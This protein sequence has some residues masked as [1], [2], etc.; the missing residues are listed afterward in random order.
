[1]SDP[2]EDQTA[3]DNGMTKEQEKFVGNFFVPDPSYTPDP[4]QAQSQTANPVDQ[5]VFGEY[6][7]SKVQAMRPLSDKMIV[8]GADTH[9]WT[10]VNPQQL[11]GIAGSEAANWFESLYGGD[12]SPWLE[13][14]LI[15]DKDKRDQAY[16]LL[17]TK[18]QAKGEIGQALNEKA[19]NLG[20]TGISARYAATTAFLASR[21]DREENG[22]VL[23]NYD[24]DQVLTPHEQLLLTEAVRA[25]VNP[26]GIGERALQ[27]LTPFSTGKVS[28]SIVRV[29]PG[30]TDFALDE[31]WAKAHPVKALAAS[32]LLQ[33]YNPGANVRIGENGV[34]SNV[35]NAAGRPIDWV[36]GPIALAYRYA[37]RGFG[38]MGEYGAVGDR[39]QYLKQ[40]NQIK[41]DIARGLYDPTEIPAAMQDY[42]RFLDWGTPGNINNQGESFSDTM[43][44]TFM[45][46]VGGWGL[47]QTSADAIGLLPGDPA[48]GAW[49]TAVGL[50]HNF[51]S[52]DPLGWAGAAK[53]AK[54]LAG[55]VRGVETEVRKAATLKGLQAAAKPVDYLRGR[56]WAIIGS[57]LDN[58]TYAENEARHQELLRIAQ[59]F[60][61]K[62]GYDVTQVSTA[63]GPRVM[64]LGM[65][66]DEALVTA[67]H[68]EQASFHTADGLVHTNRT[69]TP[70]D[71]GLSGKTSA[72]AADA[73]N[74]TMP[75]K[76]ES[77]NFHIP[78]D[79]KPVKFAPPRVSSN[80]MTQH[81]FSKMYRTPD[82]LLYGDQ[83]VDA[84]RQI[85]DTIKTARSIGRAEA[86]ARGITDAEGLLAAGEERTL[87]VMAQWAPNFDE[88]ITKALA[89]ARN[90]EDVHMVLI[91]A[92]LG[93]I[94]DPMQF[95]RIV[96]RLTNTG[97]ELATLDKTIETR[98]ELADQIHQ[99]MLDMGWN[100]KA[101][102]AS[103]SA[104]NNEMKGITPPPL[105]E[106][107]VRLFRGEGQ[108]STQSGDWFADNPTS[109]GRYG[110][111]ISYVDVPKEVAKIAQ[112]EA[113]AQGGVGY[114]LPPDVTA[115]AQALGRGADTRML[116]LSTVNKHADPELWNPTTSMGVS[117]LPPVPEGHVRLYRGHT[118]L[119]GKGLPEWVAKETE[120]AR[121]NWFTDKLEHA[122]W[123]AERAPEG[124]ISYVDVPRAEAE[125]ARV[126]NLGGEALSFSRDP[127][128]EFLLSKE[129]ASGMQP[130][131]VPKVGKLDKQEYDA[132]KADIEANGIR[133]PLEMD[134][135]PE[136]GKANM[137]E[138]F[139]RWMAARD[140][141]LERVPVRLTEAPGTE[142][143]VLGGTKL[144]DMVEN[145]QALDKQVIAEDARRYELMAER[146]HLRSLVGTD[147]VTIPMRELPGRDLLKQMRRFAPPAERTTAEKFMAA[148]ARYPGGVTTK[149]LMRVMFGGEVQGRQA[150][151]VAKKG[152]EFL[153][154]R[155]K[156][157][158]VRLGH[159]KQQ[160]SGGRH[161]FMPLKEGRVVP[162]G[163]MADYVQQSLSAIRDHAT[164]FGLADKD[165]QNLLAAYLNVSNREE[166][167]NFIKRLWEDVAD[168]SPFLDA[169][170]RRTL[171]QT[172][173]ELM[174]ERGSGY[175]HGDDE[176]F[177]IPRHTLDREIVDKQTGRNLRS[178]MP[179]FSADFMGNSMRLPPNEVM[180]EYL[181]ATRRWTRGLR[182]R[183]KLGEV[184]SEAIQGARDVLNGFTY[185]WKSLILMGRMPFA[186]LARLTGEQGFRMAAL[187]LASYANH[188]LEWLKS[189]LVKGDYARFADSHAEFLGTLMDNYNDVH[190]FGRGMKVYRR[191]RAVL[192]PNDGRAYFNALSSVFRRRHISPE[193]VKIMFRKDPVEVEN[194]LRSEASGPTGQAI[195]ENLEA[196]SQGVIEGIKN[197]KAELELLT[198]GRND[199][200]GALH[201]GHALNESGKPIEVGSRAFGEFLEREYEA[202]RYKPPQ[203]INARAS[204]YAFGEGQSLAARFRDFAF[205]QFYSRPD[206]YMSRAPMFR[207]LA[208][209]EFDRL[210]S[211]GWTAKRA[212]AAA[213]SYA[214]ETTSQWMYNL[215]SR[216]SAQHFLRNIIPFF[217]AYQELATVWL[218]QLPGRYV[219]GVGH[220][221]FARRAA[222]L[223]AAFRDIGFIKKDSNGQDYFTVPYLDKVY[224]HLTG[225]KGGILKFPVSSAVGMLP[226]TPDSLVPALGPAPSVAL[227][228]LAK[229]NA[230]VEDI[231]NL[232]LRYGNE[233]QIGPTSWDHLLHAAGVTPPWEYL[234]SDTQKL[235]M[236]LAVEDAMRSVSMDMPPAPDRLKFKSQK[237]YED[238]AKT[239]SEDLLARAHKRA[240]VHYLIR[241]LAGMFLP[242][243]VQV[244]NKYAEEMTGIWRAVEAYR[245]GKP[246][247]P[248]AA[249]PL[250]EAFKAKYPD[251]VWYTNSKTI[252]QGERRDYGDFDNF[253]K[254][255]TEGKVK[256]MSQQEF[257]DWNLGMTAY[258]QYLKDNKR[259]TN[260]MS[261]PEILRSGFQINEEKAYAKDDWS[262]YLAT[263][264]QFASL[265]DQFQKSFDDSGQ[266]SNTL[267]TEKL[268]A[269]K[270]Q[271]VALDKLFTTA[272]IRDAD[273]LKVIGKIS[274]N[275]DYV[276]SKTDDPRWQAVNWWWENVGIPTYSKIGDLYDKAFNLPAPERGPIFEKIRQI[277]N[278]MKP[279]SHKGEKY[280]TPEEVSWGRKND[281]EQALRKMEWVTMPPE[282]LTR[283]ERKKAGLGG[284][285][286][287]DKFYTFINDGQA[288]LRQ[289]AADNYVSTSS[290]DYKFN[291]DSLNT[292]IQQY[293]KEH[294]L[295]KYLLYTKEPVFQ[296]MLLAKQYDDNQTFV[297][298]AAQAR[299]VW[300]RIAADGHSPAGTTRE[301]REGQVWLFQQIDRAREIDQGFDNLMKRLELATAPSG[302]DKA[303]GYEMYFK[304]FF[305][306]FGPTPQLPSSYSGR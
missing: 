284:G 16:A 286:E 1:M 22:K 240:G 241:G 207:Q 82:E 134:F 130:L 70:F 288:K 165:V 7:G 285:P 77:V 159:V 212:K 167:F 25:S 36:S 27:V 125:A 218:K 115:R 40:A 45:P 245:E 151:R 177:M 28:N 18:D 12:I 263:H 214:A 271:L 133:E 149:D 275:I 292:A 160:L 179:A 30:S 98:A 123:Y 34:V 206:V 233:I 294:G 8:S 176:G 215:A 238:A 203:F 219:A 162:Q 85:Y 5:W 296:R 268:I 50:I 20:L 89:A 187:D 129:R 67:R 19:S 56:N 278:S 29:E 79:A 197:M 78:A 274:E 136:T 104:L 216:T 58:L 234:T 31:E 191:G 140:L 3:T 75:N 164:L 81:L 11:F 229:H 83:A 266:I 228:Q 76:F 92:M 131:E 276:A 298:I 193:T 126:S 189:M 302:R 208:V 41:Q 37:A 283:F 71:W 61:T 95:D 49:T 146:L 17:T 211:L 250:I 181:S 168:K 204:E 257:I 303:P 230:V 196:S 116:P 94:S 264:K 137:S 24:Y 65:R 172:H 235:M 262:T 156:E 121:G 247:D 108:G 287:V 33:E 256:V 39:S 120:G 132:L 195:I 194:W 128:R 26:A 42:E 269:V 59:Q 290:N 117:K 66:G 139:H 124:S 209:K 231:A 293:A 119:K 223:I 21:R 217:P 246:D 4:Y 114:L 270:Q 118:T 200:K 291:E 23:S 227:A 14:A 297:A 157:A 86:Q 201:I 43:H 69:I 51:S 255:W 142:G 289:W 222:F 107:M 182:K 155:A 226:V 111:Q 261:P 178:G 251:A 99:M 272:G 188:P 244:T 232:V 10:T 101:D 72:A 97:T 169:E 68:F 6:L 260:G 258:W 110:N 57:H 74:I 192:Q 63:Q 153:E 236:T 202:G 13:A 54:A 248:S 135:D 158:F 259:P 60:A 304:V 53:Q 221:Y 305:D 171:R 148:L 32:K 154:N 237:A 80:W 170:G 161:I 210:T 46:E 138:G 183:G 306:Y 301:A 224:E 2:Y 280:P 279:E 102:D 265:F 38:E 242:T 143:P 184:S 84:A 267:A 199:L 254:D 198:A 93:G 220:L 174:S 35:L 9:L 122:K 213:E 47:A 295:D 273:Y 48:Y 282:W 73:F 152:E 91:S 277:Q 166:W 15:Q 55:Q 225:E 163:Q 109:A 96:Q 44:D 112:D 175:L 205:N 186:L 105:Q 87:G 173:D 64:I 243:S 190:S 281:K 52:L 300:D 145:F 253:I 103:L 180:Y 147:D 249:S 144:K 88:H 150:Q 239:W 127:E 252:N 185:L 106:G 90:P 113:R 100:G 299:Q 141:G 62:K